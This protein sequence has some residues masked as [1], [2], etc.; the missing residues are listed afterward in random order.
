V[1]RLGLMDDGPAAWEAL[2]KWL[3]PIVGAMP[4]RTSPFQ[5]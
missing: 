4:D 1:V 2:G 3:T 5:G